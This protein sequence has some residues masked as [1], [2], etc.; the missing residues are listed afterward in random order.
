MS[1]LFWH[2]E[3]K[4]SKVK[5]KIPE[6]VWLNDDYLP[7]LEEAS[8]FDVPMMNDDELIAIKGTQ[9]VCDI[10]LYSNYFLC[11]FRSVTTKK[12]IYFEEAGPQLNWILHNFQIVT[13][14]GNGYDL[15]ILALALAG[16]TIA[17]L[18]HATNMIIQQE[19]KPWLVLSAFKVEQLEIDHIDLIE[20]C[21]LRASLKI[22]GGRLHAPQMRDLPFHPDSELTPDQIQIL[23]FYCINDLVT[24]DVVLQN[25]TEQLAIRKEMSTKYGIDL[26]SKSDAQIAEAVIKSELTRM[27]SKPKRPELACGKAYSYNVP[28]YIKYRSPVL[29]E[30]LEDVKKARFIMSETGKIISPNQLID[31]SS[32]GKPDKKKKPRKF[33]LF[34][35]TYA[36]G[37]GGLHSNEKSVSH[38]AGNG[39]TI[40]DF[41]VTSY[42]PECISNQNLHP[43]HL[44]MNFLNIYRSLISRR[45]T[46]KKNGNKLEADMLKIVVNGSFGKFGSMWSILFAPQLLIQTTLTGQLAILMMVEQL[47]HKGI[48]VISAN[49]DGV[50]MKYPD[51]MED[52]VQST[53]KEWENQTGFKT[54]ETEYTAI[55]ARDVNCYV[56]IKPNG[57]AKLKGGLLSNPW[58]SPGEEIFRFHKNP[59]N[60]ICVDAVVAYL[61]KGTKIETTIRES[62]DFTKF[63][64]VRV[65]KGGGV[66]NGI[67][68]GKAVRWYYSTGANGDIVYALSGNKVPKSDGAEP[69]LQMPHEFPDDVDYGRYENDAYQILKE[70][71]A[72]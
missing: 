17:E 50:V 49:T 44:G 70:I 47:N 56:A 60:T 12:C 27:G 23:K 11:A 67:Y 48:E 59:T 62:K 66:K 65:V 58:N 36:V 57:K 34:G 33:E 18:K 51:V 38:K 15:P 54:E 39:F 10:E 42:Y 9:L 8:R 64:T 61:T 21:P 69:C 22:Y 16:K 30:L 3:I 46:A 2:D 13:F 26:R 71:G 52:I 1:G 29:I 7:G 32:W 63:V 72:V 19:I 24:T 37:I 41:D 6:P 53:V 43:E 68:L 28:K 20:V 35:K 40:K 55:Y 31:P 5:A 25:L 45:I 4:P 14:N